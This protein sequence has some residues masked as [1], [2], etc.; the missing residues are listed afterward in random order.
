MVF[1]RMFLVSRYPFDLLRDFFVDLSLVFCSESSV[2]FCYSAQLFHDCSG[3]GCYPGTKSVRGLG[4]YFY[5]PF[6]L[7]LSSRFLPFTWILSFPTKL[8]YLDG[9]CALLVG[10]HSFCGI[11]G[12]FPLLCPYQWCLCVLWPW[13]ARWSMW[14][15]LCWLVCLAMGGWYF[16]CRS[17]PPNPSL[18]VLLGCL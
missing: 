18:A 1:L 8:Q 12:F 17:A 4:F 10:L 5:F 9:V 6:L 2:Y 7:V 13:L 14:L 3:V 15:H 11:P 16:P